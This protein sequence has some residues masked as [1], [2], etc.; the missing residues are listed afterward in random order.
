MQDQAIQFGLQRRVLFP[1][2]Y[3]AYVVLAALDV[4]LTVRILSLGGAEVNA[5]AQWVLHH[6]EVAGLVVFKFVAVAL[7]LVICETVGHVRETTGR[8]LAEWA[9]A[10][11][12]IPVAVG[13]IQMGQFYMIAW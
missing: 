10:L 11:T 5:I 1:W 4:M 7:V 13:A 9:V 3:C 12:S 8:R 6:G 2:L